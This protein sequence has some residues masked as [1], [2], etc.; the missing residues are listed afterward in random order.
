MN[1]M[2]RLVICLTVIL[3][4]FVFPAGVFAS[5]G[6]VPNLEDE[7]VF[8][9]TFTL[10]NGERL[11][12]SLIVFGGVVSLDEGSEINGDLVV[13]GGNV[14]AE[15]TVDGSMLA[16]GGV[17]SL[18]ATAHI[19]G[20][21]I[22]PATVLRKDEGVRIDG[23]LITETDS[24]RIPEIP[25]IDVPGIVVEPPTFWDNVSY[26]LRP[27]FNFFTN[28]V[29]ALL[30]AAIALV[31][32]LL[33]PKQG[34]R[35]SKMIKGNPVLAGGFGL[36]SVFVFA[37]GVLVLGLLSV[38]IILI[39]VT[40]PAIILLSLALAAGMF[41]GVI[42]VGSEFGRR[43]MLLVK[44]NWNTNVQV[45]V[46]TFSLVFLLG[47][48]NVAFWDILA[49]LAWTAVGAIGL[50]AVLLTRFG[51]REYVPPRQS[52]TAS[53]PAVSGDEDDEEE[54][55]TLVRKRPASLKAETPEDEDAAE[56]E[57]IAR[58]RPIRFKDDEEDLDE[59]TPEES[60]PDEDP[61]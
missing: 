11:D 27:V 44:Q 33:L 54:A 14:T 19:R 5:D 25:E 31:V 32:L 52:T 4:S 59:D 36:L 51:T 39:P 18:K 10:E 8:L 57:T 9:G 60:L 16:F 48:F 17:V 12:G 20:D 43:I 47:L 40:V 2:K 50:G 53:A 30:F 26:A 1:K 3:V 6:Y 45:A 22:A 15:G 42:V 35:V 7:V 41:F 29:G 56:M 38:T 55:E 61:A 34:E 37:F 21:L 49:S 28:I 46:G 13:F 23:Q 24:G 58:K